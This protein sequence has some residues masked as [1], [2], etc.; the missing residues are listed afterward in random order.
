[1][2]PFS[3]CVHWMCACVL[4][5]WICWKRSL[6]NCIIALKMLDDAVATPRRLGSPSFRPISTP[7]SVLQG[8]Q[9]PLHALKHSLCKD[10]DRL[11]LVCWQFFAFPIFLH[12][13]ISLFVF[14]SIFYDFLFVILLSF[15]LFFLF[16]QSP[17]TFLLLYSTFL[18]SQVLFVVHQDDLSLP[19]LLLFW[20]C[21]K[22]ESCHLKLENCKQQCQ[23][24]FFYFCRHF[25]SVVFSWW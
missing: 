12:L 4:H 6:N 5:I 2:Y 13:K 11:K 15:V 1:M 25:K 19:N 9:P 3:L 14:C 21:W 10:W 7:T 16:F 22:Q 18:I 23:M 20:I 24:I 17:Q 8:N